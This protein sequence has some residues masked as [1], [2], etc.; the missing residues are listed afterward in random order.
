MTTMIASSTTAE[1]E[2]ATAAHLQ[3]SQGHGGSDMGDG[4][5]IQRPAGSYPHTASDHNYPYAR[6]DRRT[7]AQGGAWPIWSR[8]D[9]RAS[10]LPPP[11]RPDA[12][13][14]P[15]R[16]PR[17]HSLPGRFPVGVP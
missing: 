13:L 10:L 6:I 3:R 15:R 7:A 2:S 16:A 4:K 17:V 5:S 1:I 14:H 11:V 8:H 12:A 9:D